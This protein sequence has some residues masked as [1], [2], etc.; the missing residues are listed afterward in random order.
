M[1]LGR[2]HAS[3]KRTRQRGEQT[4]SNLATLRLLHSL[5][6]E[7]AHIRE[8]LDQA[9]SQLDSRDFR[10]CSRHMDAAQQRMHRVIRRLLRK[11]KGGGEQ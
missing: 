1:N 3:L 5:E 6:A 8:A 10:R 4:P 11:S 2:H 9:W 7:M